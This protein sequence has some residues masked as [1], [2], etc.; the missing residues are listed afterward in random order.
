MAPQRG[1]CA[2]IFSSHCANKQWLSNF[3]SCLFNK[4]FC[5]IWLIVA[6]FE[7]VSELASFPGS[8]ATEEE[9]EPGT[10]CLRMH[11]LLLVTCIL[12]HYTKVNKFLFTC[13]KTTLR[14]YTSVML[15]HL[16]AS[17]SK[18]HTDLLICHYT[19][20]DLSRTSRYLGITYIRKPTARTAT[21]S[22]ATYAW[23]KLYTKVMS[24]KCRFSL[25]T[26]PSKT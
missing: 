8:C 21:V 25:G 19:K 17:L 6:S 2:Q 3:L 15:Y 9:R 13:W 11:Q 7:L 18:Q 10:H 1:E 12:L 20:Q 23:T 22:V 16:G 5:T 24:Y 26:R 4:W 14:N